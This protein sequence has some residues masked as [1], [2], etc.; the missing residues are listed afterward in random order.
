MTRS[1]YI[2]TEGY[3]KRKITYETND[4]YYKFDIQEAVNDDWETIIEGSIKWDGCANLSY[5]GCIHYC[6][7]ADAQH[8]LDIVQCCYHICSTEMP[9]WD[10][11]G[12][13]ISWPEGYE[14]HDA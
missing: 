7:F 5:E 4:Y 3:Y 8:W 12:E 10:S 6:G 14:R 9:K 1:I 2:K 11:L 13:E